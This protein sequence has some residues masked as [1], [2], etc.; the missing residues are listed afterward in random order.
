MPGFDAVF[1]AED[2]EVI[3]APVRAPQANAICKRWIDTRRRECTDRLL[4]HNERHLRLVLEEYLAHYFRRRVWLPALAGDQDQG[5]A[6]IQPGAA[7]PRP[8]PY[9]QDMAHRGPSPPRAATPATRPQ[10][11][12]RI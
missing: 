11:P 1:S 5:W 6:A 7:L 2:A 9:T 8:T 10:T 4:I 3:K 12:R